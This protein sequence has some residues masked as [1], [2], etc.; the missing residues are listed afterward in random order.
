[1]DTIYQLARNGTLSAT[2]LERTDRSGIDF[3]DPKSS[4][5]PL[6]VAVWHGHVET[7]KLLLQ[8][9]ADPNGVEGA[10]PP[11]WVAAARTR[12]NAG[13]LIQ[14]L[15]DRG[16]N[17]AKP[18]PVPGDRGSTPLLS[19]V[20][21]RLSPEIISELVDHGAD[22]DEKINR[23]S[24]RDIAEGKRQRK[25]LQAMR[26]RKQRNTTR[27]LEVGKILAFLISVV[28]C[29]NMCIH[30]AAAVCVEVATVGVVAHD[31]IK[32]RFGMT[33]K[34]DDQLSEAILEQ[35][36]KEELLEDMTKFINDSHLDLFFPP[37]H[38]FLKT[39]VEKAVNLKK[40]PDN[41]LD[42]KDLTRV[43]LYQPVLYCDDSGSMKEGQRIEH[44]RD[45]VQRITNITTRIVPDGEGIEL[46]FINE[47]T[48]PEMTRPSL[49]TIEA[50][51]GGVPFNG[52][53]E[54]GTNLR[55]RVLEDAVYAPLNGDGLQRPVLVSIITDGYP[56]GPQGTPE[57]SE[58][59]KGAILECGRVLRQHG[60]HPNVVRFQISQIGND[61]EAD[62]FLAGLSDDP[63]LEDVLYCTTERLDDK[64]RTMR[65]NEARLEQWLLELLMGP[66]IDG[67][68]V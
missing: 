52:W 60:Y 49:D 68:R 45:V 43:A 42:T 31:A 64:F 6:G 56:V 12:K 26:P 10:R 5:T 30:G 28:Y 13:R 55:R 53:T 25:L 21:N 11:L 59:L 48:T 37:E 34:L 19:A 44:Q 2:D 54:I 46:R 14:I 18:S 36:E 51:M 58:T 8:H 16:A 35:K 65:N 29:A 40:D 57:R 50:I 22:P 23:H 15:L 62:R 33:G 27:I 38:S 41:T 66:I 39:V 32:R 24:A 67:D 63:D 9:E 3:L 7:V 61:P 47:P 17:A 1:M 20:K 4:L